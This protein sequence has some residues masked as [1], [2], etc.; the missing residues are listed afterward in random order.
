MEGKQFNYLDVPSVSSKYRKKTVITMDKLLPRE[1]IFKACEDDP[2]Y[3]PN[4][5][6]RK[7]R[8]DLGV[9]PFYGGTSKGLITKKQPTKNEAMYDYDSYY[10]TNQSQLFKRIP[11]VSLTKKLPREL[12]PDCGLPSFM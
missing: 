2:D 3:N 6:I 9:I 4:Y 7:R 10:E 11:Q 8:V 1:E 12:D 5:E